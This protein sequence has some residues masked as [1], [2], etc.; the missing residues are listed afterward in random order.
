MLFLVYSSLNKIRPPTSPFPFQVYRY[1][2]K[3]KPLGGTPVPIFCQDTPPPNQ[4]SSLI[5]KQPATHNAEVLQGPI[6]LPL[7]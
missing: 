4:G 6:P 3:L 5:Q 1:D 7:L 2:L